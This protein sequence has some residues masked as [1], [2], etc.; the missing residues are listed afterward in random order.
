MARAARRAGRAVAVPPQLVLAHVAV[1]IRHH[2]AVRDARH[3]PDFRVDL[4]DVA[5]KPALLG[6]PIYLDALVDHRRR[7]RFA[8]R[9]GRA[10]R[11]RGHPS[12]QLGRKG[13]LFQRAVTAQRSGLDS[14]SVPLPLWQKMSHHRKHPSKARTHVTRNLSCDESFPHHT[15]ACGTSLW[16]IDAR[17]HPGK[18]THEARQT[19]TRPPPAARAA[20]VVS[21]AVDDGATAV[22]SR[23]MLAPA[24]S[25]RSLA[26]ALSSLAL[27]PMPSI[28]AP[29]LLRLR[30]Q[31]AGRPSHSRSCCSSSARPSHLALAAAAPPIYTGETV[32]LSIPGAVPAA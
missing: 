15:P 20:E 18:N 25:R 22:P 24:P 14:L 26:V 30:V 8:R 4:A 1:V 16:N 2:D 17:S 27:T 11:R 13:A 31:R 7:R 28:A 21:G 9:A 23:D 12:E 5:L 3:L 19:P 6:R 10:G 29:Y 32:L